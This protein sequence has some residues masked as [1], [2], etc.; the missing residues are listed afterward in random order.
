MRKSSK[1]LNL[2]SGTFKIMRNLFLNFKMHLSCIKPCSIKKI[3]LPL[4]MVWIILNVGLYTKPW[5]LDFYAV[6]SRSSSAL[7]WIQESD[8]VFVICWIHFSSLEI[9]LPNVPII[10][11]ITLAFI[12]QILFVSS[13]N[14]CYFSNFLYIPSF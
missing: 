7:F 3:S 12:F 4:C 11:G 14:L 9:T 1:L 6:P 10:T 2:V 5:E 8:I 13:Y